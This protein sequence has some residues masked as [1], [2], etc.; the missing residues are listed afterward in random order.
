MIAR[1]GCEF[2]LDV[3]RRR[4]LKDGTDLGPAVGGGVAVKTDSS[5]IWY[6]SRGRTHE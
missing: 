1:L 5:G 3:A 6:V 2:R 4:D